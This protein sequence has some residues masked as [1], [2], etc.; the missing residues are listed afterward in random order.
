MARRRFLKYKKDK[1]RSKF[2]RKVYEEL[3][4]IKDLKVSYESEKI[5]YLVHREAL[6]TP[7]FVIVSKKGKTFYLETKGRF[8]SRDRKKHLEIKEQHP[9]VDIRFLFMQDQVLYK[10]SETRY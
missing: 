3:S 10:G 1:F 6:Y 2:E 8:L 4:S 7:D 5:R 9:L